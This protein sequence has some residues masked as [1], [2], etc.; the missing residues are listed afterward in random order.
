MLLLPL[1]EADIKNRWQ[2]F[3]MAK[4]PDDCDLFD[5]VESLDAK[6]KKAWHAIVA[7]LK[8]TAKT[9]EGPALLGKN[10]SHELGSSKYKIY[11]FSHGSVRISWFYGSGNKIIICAHGYLKKT[12]KTPRRDIENAEAYY[13]A[14]RQLEG[15]K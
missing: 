6:G 2:V 15:E 9:E 13:E 12:S 7:K 4:G 3:A 5:F 10:F 1:L 14:Y 8:V 11:R